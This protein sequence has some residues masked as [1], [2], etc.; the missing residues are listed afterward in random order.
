METQDRADL[1][2]AQLVQQ[3]WQ[4]RESGAGRDIL[5]CFPH[6]RCR[7]QCGLQAGLCEAARPDGEEYARARRAWG[8]H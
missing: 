2:L 3:C 5:N 7:S 1:A 4:L 8:R 6:E